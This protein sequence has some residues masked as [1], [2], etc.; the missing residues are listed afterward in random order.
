[1][2]VRFCPV[3]GALLGPAA[4]VQEFWA[5]DNRLFLCWCA[6]CGATTTVALGALV[7]REP[8]H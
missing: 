1:V 3:C 7:G 4:F 5:A 8:E 2:D 6:A